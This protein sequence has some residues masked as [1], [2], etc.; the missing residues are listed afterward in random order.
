MR[1]PAQQAA[2]RA[3]GARSRGPITAAGKRVSS[4]N[5]LRPGLLA[6]AVLLENES[7]AG[8]DEIFHD[9]VKQFAPRNRVEMDAVEQMCAATWRIRRLWSMA[10]KAHELE[11]ASQ[12]SPDELERLVTGYDSL[13]RNRPHFLNLE[14][15]EARL[16]MMIQRTTNRILAL[17]KSG[18]LDKP[19]Q[20]VE[21]KPK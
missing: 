16:D 3:N 2:S 10:R 21:I 15:Y 6:R 5:A 7:R 1:T 14:R 11:L 20:L 12:N 9:Y 19:G 13:A 4:L 18:I 17:R 8:F